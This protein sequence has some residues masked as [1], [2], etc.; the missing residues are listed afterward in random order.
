[1]DQ[2]VRDHQFPLSALSCWLIGL[3]LVT[4]A[5]TPDPKNHRK[6]SKSPL[7]RAEDTAIVAEPDYSDYNISNLEERLK[8]LGLVDVQEVEPS[9]QID[10]RYS[11]TNNFLKVDLYE[12]FDR[13][14]LQKDVAE[15]LQ[16]AQLF[17]K[18]QYPAYSLLVFDGVRPRRVQWKMWKVLDMPAKEKTKYVSN[19]KN[20]SLHNYGAAVDLT[21]VDEFGEELDMGTEYDYFGELAYPRLEQKMLKEGKLTA[22]QFENRELLRE[23]MMNAEFTP[24]TTEWWH[25]NSC[26]R[27]EA[28]MRY[29]VVE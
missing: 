25:F 26:S 4:A 9:I 13:C 20:G 14:Y 24:I 16:L 23:V 3:I 8:N 28:K 27:K 11:T 29:R 1:M 6:P 19:P 2:K 18:S 21:I 17:L 7:T 10:M 12:D 15:K 22:Q 5:C